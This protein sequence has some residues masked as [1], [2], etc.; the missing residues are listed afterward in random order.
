[1]KVLITW[2]WTLNS[3]FKTYFNN[4]CSFSS[5]SLNKFFTIIKS[6]YCLIIIKFRI[7][8]LNN[9]VKEN[10]DVLYAFSFRWN[11]SEFTPCSKSCGGG[12]MTRKVQCLHEVLRGA[13]NTLVVDHSNCPQPPPREQLF[14]NNFDCPQRWKPGNWSKVSGLT[15]QLKYSFF[16]TLYY[17]Y[18]WQNNVIS[19]SCFVI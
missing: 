8:I 4:L 16:I 7:I 19:I 2:N 18:S 10:L 17:H 3:S 6:K 13:V 5:C 14:C 11:V 15:K 12:L 9:F 1:M